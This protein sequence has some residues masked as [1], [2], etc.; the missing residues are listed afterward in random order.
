MKRIR[1]QEVDSDDISTD[2]EISEEA[3]LMEYYLRNHISASMLDPVLNKLGRS[4]V[5]NIQFLYPDNVFSLKIHYSKY[6][7]QDEIVRILVK[8]LIT[9]KEIEEI[10][11]DHDCSLLI[12]LTRELSDITEKQSILFFMKNGIFIVLGDKYEKWKCELN[13]S[14]TTAT[15]II[16]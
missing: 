5:S 14:A 12:I 7:E 1:E 4:S 15:T 10:T 9:A 2:V 11:K 13:K 16:I 8:P 3:T 6:H